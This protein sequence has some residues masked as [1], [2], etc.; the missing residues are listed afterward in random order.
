[1]IHELYTDKITGKPKCRKIQYCKLRDKKE[2]NKPGQGKRK[3]FGRVREVIGSLFRSPAG[4]VIFLLFE[5][6]SQ[7]Q[8]DELLCHIERLHQEG[9][10]VQVEKLY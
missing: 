10:I 5:P 8:Q 9:W 4:T 6:P 2:D 7:C 3:I 1:M